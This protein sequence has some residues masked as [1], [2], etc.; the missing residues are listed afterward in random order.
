MRSVLALILA[1]YLSQVMAGDEESLGGPYAQFD[2]ETG[3]YSSDPS[4]GSSPPPV[5]QAPPPVATTPAP[6]V[7]TPT[8]INPVIETP[9]TRVDDQE[10]NTSLLML[11]GSGILLLGAYFALR[12]NRNPG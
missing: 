5:H 6:V 11:A 12:R 4:T 2:P 3:F 10:T 7:V 8:E 9:D 1:I